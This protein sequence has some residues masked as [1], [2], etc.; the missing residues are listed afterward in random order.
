MGV[1]KKT[2]RRPVGVRDGELM[3]HRGARSRDGSESVPPIDTV[4]I[5]GL[6]WD[7]A[8]HTTKA[9][10]HSNHLRC[11]SLTLGRVTL[12]MSK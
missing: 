7:G 12:N 2:V 10:Y 8:I 3:I 1:N 11:H 4:H 9:R 6:L 5:V